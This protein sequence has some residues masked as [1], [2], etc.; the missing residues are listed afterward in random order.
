MQQR[1]VRDV[2]SL[3]LCLGVSSQLVSDL[4][5]QASVSGAW[6]T[7]FDHSIT[8]AATDFLL[9]FRDPSQPNGFRQY[10]DFPQV[11]LGYGGWGWEPGNPV[12]APGWF[13][14]VHMSVIPKGEHRG[15][16]LVWNRWPVLLRPGAGLDPTDY[17]AF[18]A[19]AVVDP[20]PS[21]QPR[22]FNYLLPIHSLGD[23]AP[24]NGAPQGDLFCSGHAWSTWWLRVG[25]AS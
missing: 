12:P 2:L 13:N 24:T 17:W 8:T 11:P 9:P 4:S 21:A 19:W 23:E 7:G 20:S 18:Q 3:A 16:I 1:S 22:F 25:R 5:A 15:K 6:Q 10:F 14:A